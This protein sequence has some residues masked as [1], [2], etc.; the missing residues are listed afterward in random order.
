MYRCCDDQRTERN[1]MSAGALRARRGRIGSPPRLHCL[2]IE[3]DEGARQRGGGGDREAAV[4]CNV[5][6]KP[7]LRNAAVRR[8]V[9]LAEVVGLEL[10]NVVAKYPFERSLRLPGSSRILATETIRV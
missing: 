3:G 2:R 6:T 1:R 9:C 5:F 4:R 10:R 7:Y 8:A